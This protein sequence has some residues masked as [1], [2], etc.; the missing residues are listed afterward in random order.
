[1]ANKIDDQMS[2]IRS[3]GRTGIMT[4]VVVGYPSLATTEAVVRAMA[5]EGADLVELQIPF[6]DPLADGPVIEAACEAALAVGT[7]V[8]D[9]FTLAH[10]L[11]DTDIPLLFMAY[12]NTV[13]T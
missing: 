10:R 2:R 13:F 7:R 6:S 12:F 8:H 1:M 3:A 11:S 5:C 4:H 9:S